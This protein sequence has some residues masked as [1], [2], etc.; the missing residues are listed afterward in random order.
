M[1]IGV[2]S[3]TIHHISVH[4]YLPQISFGWSSSTG[5]CFKRVTEVTGEIWFTWRYDME[6]MLRCRSH[7][8]GQVPHLVFA[9]LDLPPAVVDLLENEQPPETVR[10]LLRQL[11]HSLR[12]MEMLSLLNR[13]IDT[14]HIPFIHSVSCRWQ[15]LRDVPSNAALHIQSRRKR[16]TAGLRRSS[17]CWGGNSFRFLL[18]QVFES[19][20]A[21]VWRHESCWGP[22]AGN[23]ERH[24]GTGTQKV[25]IEYVHIH[26][27][28]ISTC[29]LSMLISSLWG[30]LQISV[31]QNTLL[32]GEH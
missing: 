17:S 16:P 18:S 20:D 2:Y 10:Y 31:Q 12:D 13:N 6:E 14:S 30:S 23:L 7:Q 4:W 22:R 15:P 3:N 8:F 1:H 29:S 24:S 11:Q 27:W 28:L 32:L 19:S 9:V 21:L 25:L 26:M 5:I